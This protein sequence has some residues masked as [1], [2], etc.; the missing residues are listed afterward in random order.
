MGWPP[1]LYILWRTCR[2]ANQHLK[3]FWHLASVTDLVSCSVAKAGEQRHKLAAERGIRGL[4]E[5]DGVQFGS[6]R[7][8][9]LVAHQALCD[10]VD[11]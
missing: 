6:V 4:P 3:L 5:D 7:D 1:Y 2:Q 8:L 10:R 9:G 11:L